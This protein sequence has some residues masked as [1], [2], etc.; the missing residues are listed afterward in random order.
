VTLLR[1][2]SVTA[3]PRVLACRLPATPEPVPAEEPLPVEDPVTALRELRKQAFDDGYRD[4]LAAGSA[5]GRAALEAQAEALR[6]SL[7]AL[8]DA[9]RQALEAQE[10]ALVEVAFAAACRVLGEAALTREGVRGAVREALREVRSRERVRVRLPAQACALLA[11]DG[12]FVEALREEQRVELTADER[13]APGGCLIETAGGTLD[14]R[15]EVQLQQLAAALC[16]ARAAE[17][18]SP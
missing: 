3:E 14:A 11:H 7:R 15:L 8:G 17:P 18:A 12:A 13:L 5:E 1:R 10:D 2:A 6:A 9:S 4:G 16:A